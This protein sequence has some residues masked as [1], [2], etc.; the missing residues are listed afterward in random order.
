MIP[1]TGRIIMKLHLCVPLALSLALPTFAVGDVASG[2]V[3][4]DYT[5]EGGDE[6]AHFFKSAF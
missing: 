5:E 4:M 6:V 2:R 1:L 3:T